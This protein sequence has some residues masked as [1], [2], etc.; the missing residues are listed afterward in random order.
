MSLKC[1][2]EERDAACLSNEQNSLTTK[3]LNE[4][5]MMGEKSW[6]QPENKEKG[7]QYIVCI[8]PM[9]PTPQVVASAN[10]EKRTNNSLP[11]CQETNWYQQQHHDGVPP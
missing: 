1:I 2:D 4:D 11:M 8:A 6:K 9:E 10:P 3:P 7:D 5:E